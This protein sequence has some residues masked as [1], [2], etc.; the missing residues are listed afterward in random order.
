MARLG[1]MSKKVK[2][3]DLLKT[4]KVKYV[5]G[6]DTNSSALFYCLMQTWFRK[7]TS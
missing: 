1:S 4:L 2:Y 7:W 6:K 5:S 3:C